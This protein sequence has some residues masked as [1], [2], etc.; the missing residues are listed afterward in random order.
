MSLPI[1]PEQAFLAFL[2]AGRLMIQRA[3]KSG[4]C[5]FPPRVAEPVTGD[6][7]Y[8][9]VEAS[10]RGI[11]YA[12]T[13]TRPRPPAHS[14]NVALID[15]REGPR[16]MSRVEGV[17]PE[18]VAIGMQVRARIVCEDGSPIVV[19]DVAEGAENTGG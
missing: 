1:A 18:H 9:W 13:V 11:V 19:F 10:G 16:M 12:T 15:L 8:D 4:R 3:R 6:T 14:V 17:A 2:A 5:F 7:G